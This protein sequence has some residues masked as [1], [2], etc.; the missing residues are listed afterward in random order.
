[1]RT[2]QIIVFKKK[3]RKNYRRKAGHRQH[4]TVLRVTDIAGPGAEGA[5]T[6]AE[7]PAIEPTAPAKDPAVAAKDPA[8]AERDPAVAAKDPAVA[9]KDQ[10]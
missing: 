9:A 3:R 6:K 10:D 7:P 8:V 5:P 2:R 4:L 1:M